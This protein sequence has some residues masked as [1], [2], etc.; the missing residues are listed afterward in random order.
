MLFGTDIA[1]WQSI[2]ESITR[3]WL[4]RK[5][6][7]SDEEFFTP[8][9]ADKLLTRYKKPF[10]GL[11]L[12]EGVLKKIY[13]ENFQRLWGNE[14]RKVDINMAVKFCEG[15]GEKEIADALRSL[16]LRT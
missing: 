6:L 14:P 12:P 11:K 4:I 15:K 10:I 3:I 8:P 16:L 1:T 13:A 7:E 9:T 5:F 2:Q